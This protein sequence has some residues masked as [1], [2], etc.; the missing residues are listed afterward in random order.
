[1]IFPM[2]SCLSYTHQ[3]EEGLSSSGPQKLFFTSLVS[4]AYG[5]ELRRKEAE[6][7][8]EMYLDPARRN[9][10][11]C[12]SGA[13]SGCMKAEESS[14]LFWEHSNVLELELALE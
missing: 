13:M 9:F 1:M 10:V 4:A 6:K 3:K 11:E 7:E 5:S 12:S 8:G 14:P 2:S